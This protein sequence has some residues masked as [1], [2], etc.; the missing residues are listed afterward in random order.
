MSQGTREASVSQSVSQCGL[1]LILE[2]CCAIEEGLLTVI[3][4]G[5]WAVVMERS[6]GVGGA[7][8]GAGGLGGRGGVPEENGGGLC[9]V[10]YALGPGIWDGACVCES[11]DPPVSGIL[12]Q[13]WIR[14]A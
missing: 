9:V 12:I 14:G 3:K 4:D 10:G 11:W 5:S 6:G 13:A 2:D 1:E 7:P 8:G